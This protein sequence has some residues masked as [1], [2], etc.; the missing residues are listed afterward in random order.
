MVGTFFSSHLVAL[1][2]VHGVERVLLGEL[3]F[4]LGKNGTEIRNIL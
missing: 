2:D 3:G 4:D 1:D